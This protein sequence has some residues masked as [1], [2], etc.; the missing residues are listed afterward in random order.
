MEEILYPKEELFKDLNI[1]ARNS[2]R[3]RELILLRSSDSL[4]KIP[5]IMINSFQ[6]GTYVTPHRHPSDG[7]EFFCILSGQLKIVIFDE[8]GN[9]LKVYSVNPNNNPMMEIPGNTYHSVIAELPDSLIIK[10]YFGIYKPDTYKQFAKWAP[11]EDR[12][13]YFKNKK[14]LQALIDNVNSFENSLKS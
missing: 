3:K 6:P 1:K 14:Y 4:D 9:I 5:T 2:L 7:R 8:F 10:L 12:K 11:M 13:D